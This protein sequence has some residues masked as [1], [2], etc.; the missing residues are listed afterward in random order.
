[1]MG[2]VTYVAISQFGST[3]IAP[4]VA[5]VGSSASEADQELDPGEVL[6]GA[7]RGHAP[8]SATPAH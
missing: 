4:S 2:T 3:R 6:T 8:C 5:P 7:P 1:V